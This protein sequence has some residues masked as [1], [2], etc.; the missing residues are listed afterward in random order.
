MDCL[1]SSDRQA[2]VEFAWTFNNIDL[3][4]DRNYI[5]RTEV[6]GAR[7]DEIRTVS[8]LEILNV[9]KEHDGKYTCSVDTTN[10]FLS[11]E[12]E[13]KVQLR[14]QYKPKFDEKTPKYIW[15]SEETI[16]QGGQYSV[17]ISCIVAAD[18]VAKISWFYG[19][20]QEA[21]TPGARLP[22]NMVGTRVNI[23]DNENLSLLTLTFNSIEHLRN[24]RGRLN[25]YT[26]RANNEQGQFR[27]SNETTSTNLNLFSLSGEARNTFEIKI[28]RIPDSPQIVSVE[29]KDGTII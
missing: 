13:L 12:K 25:K 23:A 9:S 20:G 3:S 21:I 15:I 29:Y 28:G 8:K 5:I 24:Q 7:G 18:P 4:T 27:L 14:V 17:N 6:A 26:C 11:D 19:V 1:A 16:Q 2:S 10:A 22:S